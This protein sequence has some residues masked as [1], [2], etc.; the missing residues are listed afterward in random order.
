M[1][2]QVDI[3]NICLTILGKPNI[4]SLTDPGVAAK[5]LNSNYDI[6][7]CAL[8]SA[9]GSWRFSIKRT[10][11]SQIAGAPV[12]GPFT[13][14]FQLP[15]DYLRLLQVGDMYPGLDLADYRLGPIDADYSQE[16]NILLCDYGSPLSLMYVWDVQ[17]TTLFHPQFVVYFAAELAYLNCETITGSTER[18]QLANARRTQAMYAAVA[19]NAILN[20]PSHTGDD[21]WVASRMQ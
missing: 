9:I 19:A 8:L 12:S 15:T 3:C 2:S 7:R 20:P 16:G 17:D 10:N 14:Q 13:T 4:T 18:Q 6:V 1:S 5:T 11:L 21:T